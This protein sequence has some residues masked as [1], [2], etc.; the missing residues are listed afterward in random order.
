LGMKHR[1]DVRR[2]CSIERSIAARPFKA[3][4]GNDFETRQD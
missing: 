1:A 3:T 4:T 2:R